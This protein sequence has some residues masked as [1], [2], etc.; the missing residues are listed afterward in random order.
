MQPVDDD[1]PVAL[2]ERAENA[3]EDETEDLE[4]AEDEEGDK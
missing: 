3:D 4:Q 2:D 1:E